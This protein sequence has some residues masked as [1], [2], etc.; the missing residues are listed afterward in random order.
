MQPRA[1]VQGLAV[2][3]ERRGAGANDSEATPTSG[4][5]NNG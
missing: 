3:E 5:V 1:V 4:V 2:G